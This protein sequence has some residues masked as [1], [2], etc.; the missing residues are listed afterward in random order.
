MGVPREPLWRASEMGADP[1]GSFVFVTPQTN[2][3]VVSGPRKRV[4]ILVVKPQRRGVGGAYAGGAVRFV[5]SHKQGVGG[6]GLSRWFFFH[7]CKATRQAGEG[8]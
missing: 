8:G 2:I 4:L 6:N 5:K 3:F 7:V 1:G